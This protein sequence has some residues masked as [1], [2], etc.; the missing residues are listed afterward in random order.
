MSQNLIEFIRKK[1][2][3]FKKELGQGACGKTVLLYDDVIDEHFVCKKYSPY[4]DE[5]KNDLFQK[6]IQEIKLL[7]L[8]GHSNVVR[9]F[10][11]YLYPDQCAGYILM[12]YVEGTDILT[13]LKNY[14]EKTNEIFLQ[15][16]KGFQY[17][18][19]R[20]ILHRDIR[21]ANIMVTNGGVVKIIDFGFGKHINES[22][23]FDK[24]ITLNWWCE[25]PNDFS[26]DLY[27]FSTEVYFVGKLFEKIILESKVEH[28]A[29][30]AILKK[31]CHK[32]PVDRMQSFSELDSQLENE[33]FEGFLFSEDEINHYRSFASCVESCFSKICNSADYVMDVDEVEIALSDLYQGVMLEYYIPAPANL[34]RCFV[35][36]EYYYRKNASVPVEDLKVFLA[37]LKSCSIE[38]KNII[39]RN[40]HSRLDSL[41]RYSKV[42]NPEDIPF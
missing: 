3:V 35:N 22:N 15:V 14:P 32:N 27:N 41:E 18:E 38:K 24:S 11:Y 10:N 29:Y 23:D 34:A 20:K 36:G 31:M 21:P 37:L 30:K 42:I 16:V 40:I 17:L 28:F 1:D 39:L 9:I 19:D 25:P 26:S 8:V 5:F 6:F 7:H 13:Y 33:K 12:E 4:V 2:F